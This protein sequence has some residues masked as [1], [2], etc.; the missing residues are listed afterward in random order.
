MSRKHSSLFDQSLDRSVFVTYF[1]G[2]VVP[3]CG[4][5]FLGER[6]IPTL[7]DQYAQWGLMGVVATTG[8]LSLASFLALRRILGNA[9]IRMADQNE[10]LECLLDVARELA[11]APHAHEVT[12]SATCW[13]HRLCNAD[14]SWVLGR[15][16]WDKPFEALS[17]RGDHASDWLETH[18]EEW[19]DLVD[20]PLVDSNT[21]EIQGSGEDAP[22]L[23]M[24]PLAGDIE[25][26]GFLVVA[27]TSGAFTT[28]EV[29]AL[30][31]LSA[32]AGVALTNAERGDSQRNFFSHMTDLVVAAL[33]THIQYRSGHASHVAKTANRI[34]R[35]MGLDDQDLHDLHFAA[36]LHD[37]GMLKIP[38][39]HQQ[40]PKF[41]R[42]HSTVGYK[43]LSRIRVWEK[44]AP[45]VLQHHERLDGTGYPDG[46]AGDD[47]CI[48]ARI[49]AVCDAWDA[50]RSDDSHRPPIPL[51]EALAELTSN[52]G[53]Q[54]D[55]DVVSTFEAL[56]RE[57]VL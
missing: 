42:K 38:A 49:L 5:A 8:I 33:D 1:L 29:D 16:D 13:A 2:G 40:D 20:R 12:E 6:L 3:L 18:L 22:S 24:T 28:T 14:A 54:F 4:F 10:R 34:G 50:M 27:R 25:P 21:I 36:L 11:E 7:P 17:Q 43:M 48:G 32:Q 52:V 31:T 23:V 47:I 51:D 57:G 55:A 26:C 19:T 46:I 41:F 45:I 53:T 35:S 56:A 30:R 37:V 39:A 15:Q 44:A 9:I